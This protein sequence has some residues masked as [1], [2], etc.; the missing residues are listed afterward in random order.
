MAK[1]KVK[2]KKNLILVVIII[3]AILAG[4][5][6]GAYKLMGS[7]SKPATKEPASEF[8]DL[9]YYHEDLANRYEAYQKAH[10]DF[11]IEEVVTNVNIGLDKEFYAKDNIIIQKDPESLDTIVNKVYKLEDDWE[12][13]DLVSVTNKT[14]R[15]PTQQ[16]RKGAAAAFEEFREACMEDGVRVNIHSGYRSTAFQRQIFDNMTK[17]YGQDHADTVS[18]RPGHSEHTTGL[19]ADISLDNMEFT[20]IDKHE[21]YEDVISKLD[22]FGF[23]LRYP[24][25]KTKYTGYSY[26]SWHIRYL[27]KELAKEVKESGLTYDQYYARH[28]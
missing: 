7:D 4:L 1:Y 28:H 20:S 18:S 14:S 8:A 25:G 9:D 5:G 2:K 19:V 16:M 23:I 11:N 27:G 17:V 3:V 21:K 10:K 26:E 15:E 12:P 13:S 24:K 22:D 6:F